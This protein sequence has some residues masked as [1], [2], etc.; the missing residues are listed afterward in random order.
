[1]MVGTGPDDAGKDTDIVSKPQAKILNDLFVKEGNNCPDQSSFKLNP[2]G[3]V[4]ICSDKT[5]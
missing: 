1:M 5:Q 4:D 2:L 3:N